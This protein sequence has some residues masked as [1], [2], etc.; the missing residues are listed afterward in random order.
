M[1][2][3]QKVKQNPKPLST[4]VSLDLFEWI[5]PQSPMNIF[6]KNKA[7]FFN[8]KKTEQKFVEFAQTIYLPFLKFT[9]DQEIKTFLIVTG[10]FL[11]MA[12]RHE[13]KIIEVIKSL[14]VK[15]IIEL[16][17][18]EYQGSSQS[19]IYNSEWWSLGVQ[20]TFDLI[21]K[22]MQITPTHTFLPQLF[23]GLELE[24][25]ISRTGQH[26]FLLPRPSKK[27]FQFDSLLSDFRRFNGKHVN[28]IE[29]EEDVKCSF[30]FIYQ[31]FLFHING[32]IL[33]REQS[34]A[35]KAF[36]MA[37]GFYSSE[38]EIRKSSSKLREQREFVRFNEKPNRSIFSNLEKSVIR[39]LDYGLNLIES[40]PNIF[41]ENPDNHEVLR[42]FETVHQAE[43]LFFLDKGMYL[44]KRNLFF[45]SPYEAFITVQ[46]II[47]KL[48]LT[49]QANQKIS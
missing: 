13:P 1:A 26:K 41:Y 4:A 9:L 7:L 30:E 22:E 19:V 45:N 10:R 24:K 44:E 15:N 18:N 3:L 20:K 2:K 23:R 43:F 34:Q 6:E 27:Y 49:V 25:I 33:Q 32:N 38:F 37:V 5:E 35:I 39:L 36:S 29:P 48:E 16:T 46:T 42:D 47:T 8:A 17:V 31:G 28:W 14:Q 21:V 11:E 40:Y 12:I